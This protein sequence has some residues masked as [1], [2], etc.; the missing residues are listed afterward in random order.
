DHRHLRPALDVVAD[1]LPAEQAVAD[2][3]AVCLI[4]IESVLKIIYV[5]VTV[6]DK[7]GI[8]DSD[9]L[10]GIIAGENALLVAGEDAVLND[11]PCSQIGVLITD[12]GAIAAQRVRD[13]RSGKR[14]PV[15]RKVREGENDALLVRQI[16]RGAEY[17]LLTGVGGVDLDRHR[18]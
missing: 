13:E 8:D 17:D 6:V 18:P 14:Q 1:Q 5:G 12:A 16:D 9:R 7:A 15:Y 4:Y 11:Q 3:K 10:A 2:A